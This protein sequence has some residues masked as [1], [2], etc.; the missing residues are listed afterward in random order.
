[1]FTVTMTYPYNSIDDEVEEDEDD[2]EGEEDAEEEEEET[3]PPSLCKKYV[4]LTW[5]LC[6][7][8]IFH[9]HPDPR[10]SLSVRCDR[11]PQKQGYQEMSI[12]HYYPTN[13]FTNV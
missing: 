5:Y 3:P 4:N 2:N 1:M 6:Q 11:S 8:L 7:Y 10:P 9:T 12:L 13:I